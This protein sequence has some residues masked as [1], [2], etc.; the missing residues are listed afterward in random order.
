ML[1]ALCATHNGNKIRVVERIV[2]FST[3]THPIKLRW[4]V[5]KK[6]FNFLRKYILSSANFFY[7]IEKLRKHYLINH[8]IFW[9]SKGKLLTCKILKCK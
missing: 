4:K 2:Y 9:K 6:V 5:S 1:F 8:I 3:H 7:I